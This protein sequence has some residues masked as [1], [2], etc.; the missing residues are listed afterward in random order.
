M[1]TTVVKSIGTAG[2]DYSTLQ[3][4][5]DACP[6][7]LVT[8]D[9]IWKGECYNDSEFTIGGSSNYFT[10]SGQTTDATRYVWLT[11]AAGQSFLD[12]AGKLTNA[13]R[14]NQANGVGFKT[15]T[16]GYTAGMQISA[17]YTR[18]ENIQAYYDSNYSG[19]WEFFKITGSGCLVQNCILQTR[20]PDGRSIGLGATTKLVNVL[21]IAAG[22]SANNY[23][24]ASG[25]VGNE[26]HNVTFV[27]P[28][29][30][31]AATTQGVGFSYS[32][33]PLCV[34]VAVFGWNG[35]FKGVMSSYPAGSDY[36]CTDGASAPGANS[37]TGKT[38]SSQFQTVTDAAK[39]FRVK[40]GSDLINAGTPDAT[41][42]GG[43]DIIGQTRSATAP[44]I[45]AWE[46]ITSGINLAGAASGVASGAGSLSTG[47]AAV[48]SE[49]SIASVSGA[50]T[51]SIALIGAE[52]TVATA[53]GS[54]TTNIGLAGSSASIATASANLTAGNG[55][56]GGAVANATASGALSSNITLSG[57]AIAQALAQAGLSTQIKAAGSA[58][59]N[60]SGQGGLSTQIN[61]A[62]AVADVATA[63]GA[64]GTVIVLT[65]AALGVAQASGVLTITAGYSGATAANANV[66]GTLTTHIEV[67][68][69]ALAQ[70]MATG[71]LTLQILLNGASQAVATVNGTLTT[72]SVVDTFT[73][74]RRVLFGGNLLGR[75]GSQIGS[76]FL[77]RQK[78]RIG[79]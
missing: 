29:D 27:R 44:T 55:L 12:S 8:V 51:T 34:N 11:T 18:I 35:G 10:I 6:V 17:N 60:T 69:A 59:G 39:D 58:V 50:L 26:L 23:G 57:A 56:S 77:S 73:G 72:A 13:M 66:Q 43:L 38:F 14:Y 64:L 70:A 42:T 20:K 5:E 33:Y 24:V 25:N 36:N 32:Y 3:S 76:R 48:G 74:P 31:A 67:S 49:A 71:S 75:T 7:N 1:T 22:T 63:Q 40:A 21:C 52:L 28:S 45:G 79:H 37:L 54:M 4:W 68:A 65:G 47:I 78:T 62:G 61:A 19:G 15:I 16:T 41:Y 53:S 30:L 2:R 46:F 9:Q